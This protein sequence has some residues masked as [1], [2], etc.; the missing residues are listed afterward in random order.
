MGIFAPI[1]AL[2]T[3]GLSNVVLFFLLKLPYLK[4]IDFVYCDTE[5]INRSIHTLP[6]TSP[7]R[8]K[9]KIVKHFNLCA[10]LS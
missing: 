2:S 3:R 6:K 8:K 5:S 10:A 9:K 1:V 7:M 4:W